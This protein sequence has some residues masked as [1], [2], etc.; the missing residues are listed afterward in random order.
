M[1]WCRWGSRCQNT[2][3][4][5]VADLA[6][7]HCPGSSL[8]IYDEG[9]CLVCCDCLLQTSGGSF[10]CKTEREMDAHILAHEAAGHHVRRSLVWRALHPGQR[11]EITDE[12]K[13]FF[14]RF[15]R[16]GAAKL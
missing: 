8:Y 1:S 13:R 11:P 5:F 9:D 15:D 12:W 14:E 10:T 2:V 7:T 3:P 6:C 4:G 16:L